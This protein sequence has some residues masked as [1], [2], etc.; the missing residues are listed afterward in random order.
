MG[1]FNGAGFFGLFWIVFAVIVVVIVV[2]LVRGIGQWS[3]NN[4][5]PVLRVE[6]TVRAKR[7]EVHHSHRSASNNGA[8]HLSSSTS[9]YVTFEV[10]S[11]DRLEL[12]VDGGDYGQL[13]EG[14]R[15][16]LTFQGTRFKEFVRY[17]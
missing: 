9:Y 15:G 1:F 10:E 3:K 16:R 5:S 7:P 8:M 2:Q 12:R 13:V 6:A 14:D 17:R 4:A 11:G